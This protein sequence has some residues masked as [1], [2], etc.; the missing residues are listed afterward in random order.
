[1]ATETEGAPAT[2]EVSAVTA[3]N[4]LGNMT[5]TNATDYL[6]K[7][8]MTRS[9]QHPTFEQIMEAGPPHQ[10][11]FVWQCAFNGQVAQGQGRS[12][13][14]AKNAAAKA[15]KDSLDT[16]TLPAMT[17]GF[18]AAA[19]NA[20]RKNAGEGKG[21]GKRQ[22]MDPF[23]PFGHLAGGPGP[24]GFGGPGFMG[25]PMA[26]GH[27]MPMPRLTAEDYHVIKKHERVFPPV[28][29]L[30]SIMKV[31]GDVEEA[32]TKTAEA[33]NPEVKEGEEKEG[34][35]EAKILGVARVGDLAK[36]LLLKGERS[37]N[38]VLMCEKPPG[39]SLLKEV[40]KEFRKHLKEGETASTEAEG[41]KATPDR[42]G[43][44]YEIHEFA[45]QAGFC[46]VSLFPP[47][48]KPD[49]EPV[50]PE[51]EGEG[52]EGEEEK[53][54]EEENEPVDDNLPY[55]VNVTLTCTKLRPN[56]AEQD[57]IEVVLPKD[58]LPKDRCVDALAELRHSKWFTSMAMGVPNCVECIRILRDMARRDVK[59]Q[60][61][62]DWTIELIVERTLTTAMEPLSPSKALMR[63]FE[64]STSLLMVIK[65]D[66]PLRI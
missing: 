19:G 45:D 53:K 21:D 31:V 6:H 62:T 28:R 15:L 48:P 46:V 10:R 22:R 37:V 61:L 55:A 18:A 40:V 7:I 41:E 65:I 44:R 30:D 35:K 54:E 20:K 39:L 14:E 52:G 2:P 58:A 47:L 26:M 50:D 1:M 5:F 56:N 9:L 29:D 64:V 38:A 59:W 36:G 51:A 66:F 4:P 27:G 34:D 60:C 12:K 63:V 16:S 23:G 25:G 49:P 3:A 13:K 42:Q 32:L 17:Q 24:M 8:A 11:T 57:K 43:P 33:I